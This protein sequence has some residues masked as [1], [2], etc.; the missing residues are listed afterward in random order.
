MGILIGCQHSSP[1]Y[2]AP[3]PWFP[4]LLLQRFDINPRALFVEFYDL[5]VG[6]FD[7][8]FSGILGTQALVVDG[9][10]NNSIDYVVTLANFMMTD[11]KQ[12]LEVASE[13]LAARAQL[14]AD[15]AGQPGSAVLKAA[16]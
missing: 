2:Y 1:S 11:I 5:I 8:V 16:G 9:E 6:I 12:V 14:A 7:V 15:Q 13:G 10:I 3:F 4:T